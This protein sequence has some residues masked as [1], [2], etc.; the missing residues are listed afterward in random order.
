MK[1]KLFKN[2]D[3]TITIDSSFF[4]TIICDLKT[5]SLINY[6]SAINNQQL[7]I[8]TRNDNFYLTKRYTHQNELLSWYDGYE[9]IKIK[10]LFN[11]TKLKAIEEDNRKTERYGEGAIEIQG[12][13]V[14]YC[15]MEYKEICLPKNEPWHIETAFRSEGKYLTISEDGINNRPWKEEEIK[16]IRQYIL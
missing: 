12:N 2:G 9:L 10:E 4:S 5:E 14:N 6:C 16:M 11:G 8:E 15:Y 3:G 1:Q 13:S 7:M